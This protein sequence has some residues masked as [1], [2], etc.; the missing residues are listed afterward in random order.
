MR[1][2][3]MAFSVIGQSLPRIDG[4]EK[5]TGRAQFA[6]DYDVRGLLHARL[7]LSPH[8]HAAIKRL[9]VD[10]ARATPGAVAVLPPDDLPF[11]EHAPD[12]RRRCLPARAQARRGG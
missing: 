12:A 1:C 3:R 8:A 2:V 4:E 9:P 11:G 6:A 7:L 10:P 5:V